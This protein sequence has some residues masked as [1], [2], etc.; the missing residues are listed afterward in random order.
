MPGQG[1]MQR[2]PT[3]PY[4]LLAGVVPC[5]P[6]WLVAA[7]KLVG[8]QI[9]PEE[10]VVVKTFRDVLDHIPQY[11]VVAVTLPIGLP[12]EPHRGGRSADIAARQLL[13]FPHAGAIGATPTRA[14]LA[15][16]TYE[17]ARKTNGGL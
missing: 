13:G 1:R 5:P 3:L 15:C 16:R 9:Y 17:A 11:K 6:G 4:D 10:P 12:T 2:G 8:V 14:A 7:G